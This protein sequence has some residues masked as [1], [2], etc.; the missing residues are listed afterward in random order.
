MNINLDD[1]KNNLSYLAEKFGSDFVAN[2]GKSLDESADRETLEKFVTDLFE[3]KGTTYYV[4]TA[5][6]SVRLSSNTGTDKP[7]QSENKPI[8]N[9]IVEV[10]GEKID[11]FKQ[12]SETAVAQKAIDSISPQ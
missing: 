10:V 1:L 4:A 7:K 5:E 9:E 3:S 8:Q 6:A 12:Q 2:I 11:T